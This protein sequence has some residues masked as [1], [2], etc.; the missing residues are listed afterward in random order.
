MIHDKPRLALVAA[1]HTEARKPALHDVRKL[2]EI[3][4]IKPPV[5]ISSI[6]SSEVL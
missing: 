4:D 1:W 2:T 6:I 5:I 3:L